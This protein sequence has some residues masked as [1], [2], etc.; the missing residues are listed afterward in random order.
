[1]KGKLRSRFIGPF[2]VL[3]RVGEV[4]YRLALPPQFSTVHNVFHVSML[5]KY[6]YDPSHE[7]SYDD[8]ILNKDMTYEERPVKILDRKMQQLRNRSIPVV[9][10]LWRNHEVEEATWEPEALLRRNYPELFSKSFFLL[11]FYEFEDQI[12][13]KRGRM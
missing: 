13:F 2:E 10:V 12:L 6:V 9:K 4:A 1:M 5:R 11:R 3:D 7:S 8:I